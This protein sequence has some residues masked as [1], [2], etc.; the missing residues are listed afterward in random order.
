[1]PIVDFDN[2]S[3]NIIA[4]LGHGDPVTVRFAYEGRLTIKSLKNPAEPVREIWVKSGEVQRFYDKRFV[5][6]FY[7][8]V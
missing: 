1:M 3:S 8:Y 2:D 4:Q 7:A 6:S 5:Y